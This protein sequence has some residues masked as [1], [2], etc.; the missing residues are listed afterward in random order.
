MK[1]VAISKVKQVISLTEDG[2]LVW[3]VTKAGRVCAGREAGTF[4]DG[5][6]RV[7]LFGVNI[8]AHRVAFALA[9]DRWPDGHI[10]HVNG[11]KL[12]NRPSNLREV[13]NR[14]NHQNRP[15]HRSGRL[16]GTTRLKK[17]RRWQA[18][19]RLGDKK[20]FLGTYETE[21]EAHDAYIT[22]VSQIQS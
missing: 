3:I 4:F 10:D 7:K 9:N 16:V 1:I 13:S 11:N 8:L 20:K 17:S 15:A 19:A 14:E 21:Q 18:Q 22:F 6:K 2:R 12:D 5:Y